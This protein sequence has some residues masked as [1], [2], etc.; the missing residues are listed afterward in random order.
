MFVV[1]SRPERRRLARRVGRDIPIQVAPHPPYDHFESNGRS[2]SDWR[3]ALDAGQHDVVLFFGLVRPYKGLEILLEAAKHLSDE[4]DFVLVVAGEHYEERGE[5]EAQITR[6]GIGDRVRLHDAYVP[7]EDVA[8][9]FALADVCVL[10]YRHATGSGVANIAVSHDV[11]LVMSDLPDLRDAFG[12]V[13]RWFP[14][15][16]ARSM[17]RC[18]ED[19][20]ADTGSTHADITHGWNEVVE[21]LTAPIDERGSTTRAR[22]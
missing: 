10:P 17:A 8:G 14:T 1:Q 9:L 11:P 12:D 20:L 13:P 5:Y 3:E 19:A 2:A 22:R 21:A 18:I 16:D 4:R 7:N 15:G 6:L